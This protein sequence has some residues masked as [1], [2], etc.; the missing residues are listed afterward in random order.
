MVNS[1]ID[2]DWTVDQCLVRKRRIVTR[3]EVR[4]R[5]ARTMT[6][7]TIC[8][9]IG[10]RPVLEAARRVVGG[11]QCRQRSQFSGREAAREQTEMIPRAQ[12]VVRDAGRID[13]AVIQLAR[14]DAE[15]A[16]GARRVARQAILAAG[17]VPSL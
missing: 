4:D 1:L 3:V 17:V 5:S 10:A 2:Q 14:L 7:R 12:L 6:L 16:T 9:Q 8:I 15:H 13:E 11:G